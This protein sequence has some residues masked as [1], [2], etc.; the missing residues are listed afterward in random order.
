MRK[1]TRK[2]EEQYR[3]LAEAAQDLIYI[4]TPNGRIEFS[5]SFAEKMFG[6]DSETVVGRDVERLF[7]PEVAAAQRRSILKV[8]TT[9]NPI[10]VQRLTP[11]PAGARWL[12]TRLVP[13]KD[14]A[15]TVT[16]VLGM[17]LF[18]RSRYAGDR[19]HRHLPVS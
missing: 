19:P 4:L 8:V 7:P 10:E 16:A 13:I 9:G 3:V 6:L 5:N 18:L 11:F 15:G 1:R 12:E 2:S 14:A 17:R